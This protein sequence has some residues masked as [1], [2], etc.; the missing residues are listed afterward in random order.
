MP[1]GT[2]LSPGCDDCFICDDP[3][4]PGCE[5]CRLEDFYDVNSRFLATLNYSISNNCS[6]PSN[7][8][9]CCNWALCAGIPHP[10]QTILEFSNIECPRFYAIQGLNSSQW[11]ASGTLEDGKTF[12][13]RP[14]TKTTEITRFKVDRTQPETDAFFRFVPSNTMIVMVTVVFVDA[15]AATSKTV[16]YEYDT[17]RCE[18]ETTITI[19]PNDM[20]FAQRAASGPIAVTSDPTIN[21]CRS[22]WTSL[23]VENITDDC[24]ANCAANCCD[25]LKTGS[26]NITS[27]NKWTIGLAPDGGCHPFGLLWT[28]SLVEVT[29]CTYRASQSLSNICFNDGTHNWRYFLRQLSVYSTNSASPKPCTTAE[30]K[31]FFQNTTTLANASLTYNF[32]YDYCT[33]TAGTLS[34]QST[35]HDFPI[36]APT[37][38][39]V[40][41]TANP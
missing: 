19:D 23:V 6:N 26:P 34:L 13:L 17:G 38:P 11:C 15:L 39:A 12:F 7:Y 4:P 41:I 33:Y 31:L 24:S 3:P 25:G 8:D 1:V 36:S 18:C 20:Y 32:A 22:N 40:S 5:G 30:F 28:A 27:A 9:P 29:P 37:F 2:L 35:S 16:I 21:D 10:D 14:S